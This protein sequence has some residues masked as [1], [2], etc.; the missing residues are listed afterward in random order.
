M[1]SI[2]FLSVVCAAALCLFLSGILYTSCSNDEGL[3]DDEMRTLAESQMTRAGEGGSSGN[4]TI[5]DLET[6]KNPTTVYKSL[7]TMIVQHVCAVVDARVSIKSDGGFN[8]TIN[9]QVQIT[10]SQQGNPLGET[11]E[12]GNQ[13]GQCSY[14]IIEAKIKKISFHCGTIR[15][16]YNVIL[17]NP[18]NKSA[19][20]F[21]GTYPMSASATMSITY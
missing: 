11:D 1:R 18:Q 13:L 3:W 20:Y 6:D 8:N 4:N 10:L 19:T 15:V 2:K 5:I 16:E 14:G 21:K 9:P 17:D 12:T 7:D